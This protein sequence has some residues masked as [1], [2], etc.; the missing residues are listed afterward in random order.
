LFGGVTSII[1]TIPDGIIDPC[2]LGNASL[3]V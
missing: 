3:L 2:A 1:P